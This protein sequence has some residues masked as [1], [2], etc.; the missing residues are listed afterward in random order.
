MIE[1]IA[2]LPA[3]SSQSLQLRGHCALA[4]NR[5]GNKRLCGPQLQIDL[6]LLQES[7]YAGADIES[8]AGPVSVAEPM[9]RA[10]R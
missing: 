4:S 6:D 5:R 7:Q 1:Y 9:A 3:A 8:I 2:H 10:K